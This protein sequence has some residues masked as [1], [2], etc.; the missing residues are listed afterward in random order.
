MSIYE[1]YVQ[2]LSRT[3]HKENVPTVVEKLS[4]EE[5]YAKEKR[6]RRYSFGFFSL[7]LFFAV[8]L[9]IT[10]VKGSAI[11][12]YVGE[13]FIVGM[14][15]GGCLFFF[16]LFL[17]CG[18]IMYVLKVDTERIKSL[19]SVSKKQE[20]SLEERLVKTELA[21]LRLEKEGKPIDISDISASEIY[22]VVGEKAGEKVGKRIVRG[23]STIIVNPKETPKEQKK[24]P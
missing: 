10:F 3:A 2:D 21:L 20:D 7:A 1:T 8:M 13:E 18:A 14:I 11:S 6:K 17:F 16:L 5:V 24:A 9:F 23:D 19:V 12:Y 15:Q 4:E 22:K